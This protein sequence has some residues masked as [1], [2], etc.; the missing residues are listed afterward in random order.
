MIEAHSGAAYMAMRNHCRIV[1][2]AIAGDQA[3]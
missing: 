3:Y 2:V 1:P